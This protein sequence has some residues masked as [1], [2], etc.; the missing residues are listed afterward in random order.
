MDGKWITWVKFLNCKSGLDDA[1][2]I[3]VEEKN[4]SKYR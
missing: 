3:Q 2:N 1:I 4:D